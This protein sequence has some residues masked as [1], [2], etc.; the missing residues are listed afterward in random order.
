M[1]DKKDNRRPQR[2]Q[3]VH[4]KMM[5]TEELRRAAVSHGEKQINL[6]SIRFQQGREIARTYIDVMKSY[7]RLNVHSGN[8]EHENGRML[9]R[10]FCRIEEQHFDS[11]L[12][13]RSAKLDFLTSRRVEKIS[14]IG[15]GSDLFDAFCSSFVEFCE[16]EDIAIGSLC[17]LVRTKKGELA[18]RGFPLKLAASESLVSIGYPYIIAF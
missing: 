13:T 11:P 5:F 16:M 7:A 1:K 14:L 8:F 9:V 6:Q 4:N 3:G 15:S 10:G 18:E 2:L 17:A 12:M